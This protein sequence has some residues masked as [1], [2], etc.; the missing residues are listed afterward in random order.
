MS[1][2]PLGDASALLALYQ[3][4]EKHYKDK[5][6]VNQAL[7]DIRLA[8]SEIFKSDSNF[9]LQLLKENKPVSA[10]LVSQK[11]DRRGH[12]IQ[13][14]RDA[15]T[16]TPG[17]TWSS[18]NEYLVGQFATKVSEILLGHGVNVASSSTDYIDSRAQDRHTETRELLSQNISEA[19]EE[20]QGLRS[21][22]GQLTDSINVSK[23]T[24][25]NSTLR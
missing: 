13:L 3:V 1:I 20:I 16:E 15:Y 4:L 25:Q 22:V 7:E 12:L 10:E 19:K 23:R 24:R 21:D 9:V 8:V 17:F 14:F 2:V 11:L 18:Y 5:A 6:A